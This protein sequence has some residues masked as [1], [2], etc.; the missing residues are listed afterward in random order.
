MRVLLVARAGASSRWL[1]P[2]ALAALRGPVCGARQCRHGAD[3][4]NA[5]Q[6]R[7]LDGLVRF[8]VQQSC[9]LV[10]VALRCLWRWDSP[11]VCRPRACAALGRSRPPH[12][13]RRPRRSARR[14]CAIWVC[15]L[16][17]MPRSPTP[18]PPGACARRCAHRR[19]GQRLAAGRAPS[20]ARR[21]T[22]L[23]RHRP[24]RATACLW[25]RRRRDRRR[26]F[27]TGNEVS[28]LAFSD[29]TVRP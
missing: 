24:G 12:G 15:P 6:S 9:G 19:Q 14:S 1:G 21:W 26:A 5:H 10:V 16:P 20:S 23:R 27:L 3:G 2:G 17:T 25:R 7:G 22:G 4:R 18:M 13:S 28:V 29:L 8:A 11:I